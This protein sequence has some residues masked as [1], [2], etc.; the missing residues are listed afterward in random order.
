MS[1]LLL[2][3][4]RSSGASSHPLDA[5]PSPPPPRF[6][7]G[8]QRTL[9]HIIGFSEK[10]RQQDGK[11]EAGDVGVEAY[12]FIDMNRQL[13][14]FIAPNPLQ[15]TR[16]NVKGG[17]PHYLRYNDLDHSEAHNCVFTRACSQKGRDDYG[18]P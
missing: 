10:L 14:T 3:A 9:G 7:R 13:R 2:F 12:A 5:S 15:R 1:P 11:Q 8:A 4:L 17:V 18:F 6:A 16:E